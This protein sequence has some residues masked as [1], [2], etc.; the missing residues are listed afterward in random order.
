M[1]QPVTEITEPGLRTA[2]GEHHRVDTIIYGTGFVANEFLSTIDVIGVD[3]RHLRD[4]WRDGAEAYLGISVTGYPNFLHAVRPEHQRRELDPL[5]PRGPEPLRH[6]RAPAMGR[7]GI[8]AVDVRRRAMTSYN[9]RIQSA[10]QGTVWLSGCSNYFTRALGQGG[11]PAPLQRGVVLAAHP[12]V[13]AVALPDDPT[14]RPG[15]PDP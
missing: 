14:G 3:G 5:L 7:L 12:S 9:R 1:T 4:D 8:G 11:H 15:R 10:M 2:D 13:P 6:G